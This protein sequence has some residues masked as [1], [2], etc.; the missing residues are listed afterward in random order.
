MKKHLTAISV[1]RV[2]PPKQ[3]T[4]EIFDLGYPG[5]A[6]RV[7]HGGAKSF[8]VFYRVGGKL[9]RE[10]LGRWPEV[11]LARARDAWR[12]T[13]EAIAKGDDPANR[14]GAKNPTLLFE[15]VVEEW[16]RRD[17]SKNKQSSVYQVTRSVEANLLP[18]WRG[19][20]VDK[21]SKADIRALLDG[22]SDRGAPIM[23]RRLQAYLNRLF[24]WCIER[25]ILAVNPMAGMERI[26]NGKS[27][28]RVLCDQELAKVWAAT[29]SIGLF[30][31]ATRLLILTGARREEIGQLRWSEI[32]GDTIR[33]EGARTKNGDPHDIPLS[34][35]A[36]ELLANMP[37]IAGSDYVF[38]ITGAKPMTGWATPKRNLDGESGVTDWVIHDLR[39]TTATGMQR[40]GVTLQVV[41]AVLG[42]TSGSRGG[43]VGVYQRHNYAEEKRAALEAWGKHVTALV[44]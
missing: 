10:S 23:A 5:L 14:E 11:T 24:T 2:K 6:L 27:R 31:P 36:C 33:L 44:R 21:I 42:H 25:D 13:R 1:E 3:G 39:R 43:I 32:D 17:Q 40:L 18:A 28:E 16:L 20:P 7:G 15:Q 22:I 41:E 12:K 9:K 26:A 37:R 35:P 29:D 19:K 30:G 8:E 4:L 38:T 34:A